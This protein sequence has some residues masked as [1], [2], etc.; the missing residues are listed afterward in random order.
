MKKNKTLA[1]A[2]AATLLVGG[3]F[4]GTKALFTDVENAVGELAISTGDVDIEVESEGW[5][6]S[7]NGNEIADGT[8]VGGDTGLEGELPDGG[9]RKDLGLTPFANNLKP[10]D[11]LTKTIT[12]KNIGTLQA[13][14][15]LD[16]TNVTAQLGELADLIIP[17][18]TEI[19]DEDG[20]GLFSPGEEATFELT[21]TVQ[22]Q[23]SQHN[24][25]GDNNDTQ[26]N[27]VVN[28]TDAWVLTA[29]QQDPKDIKFGQPVPQP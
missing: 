7:R 3:T 28:L 9:D 5:I 17:S 26:E 20:N 19:I 24:I 27:A 15:T 13:E 16:S 2:L 6:L 10:G 18:A 4:V 29:T 22:N 11:V 14:L 21:L 8:S 25:S 12:V 23:N 1:Y